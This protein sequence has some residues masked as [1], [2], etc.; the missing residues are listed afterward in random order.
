MS[1][2]DAVLA[3]NPEFAEAYA[4]GETWAVQHAEMVRGV[5]GQAS[6]RHPERAPREDGRPRNWCGD[7]IHPEGCVSCDLDAMPPGM[8]KALGSYNTG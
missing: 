1:R 6:R 8:R 7:C 5:D 2:L 4:R 3:M